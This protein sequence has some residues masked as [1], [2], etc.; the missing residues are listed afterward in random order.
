MTYATDSAT[1]QAFDQFRQFDA[2]TQLALL[3]YGYLDIKDQ[4]QPAPS[5]PTEDVGEAVFDQIRSLPKQQQLQAQR[6]IVACTNNDITRAYS[7]LSSSGKLFLWLRLAQ[8]MENGS[9]TPFPS[10]YKLPANT[11][12]FVNQIKGLDFEQR[13]NFTRSAVLSMGANPV[14][15]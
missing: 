15:R 4:L 3:W 1:Q 9:I 5:A 12:S 6:D 14:N 2:D 8:G 11:E 13:L 7:A 10:D